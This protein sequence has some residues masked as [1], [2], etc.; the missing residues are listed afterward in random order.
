M[1][2]GPESSF[3]Y[4]RLLGFAEKQGNLSARQDALDASIVQLERNITNNQDRAAA[5]LSGEIVRLETRLDERMSR[6]RQETHA[7]IR[8]QNAALGNLMT[9][10]IAALGVVMLIG[11][12]AIEHIEVI[13]QVLEMFR[14]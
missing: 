11:Y 4:E 7:L 13:V 9:R 10:A 5:H 14:R 1:T 12:G 6:E 2:D 3:F 8:S